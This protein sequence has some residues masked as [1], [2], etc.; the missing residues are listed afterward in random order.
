MTLPALLFSK[1]IPSFTS[2]NVSAI[3]PIILT[4]IFY[5]PYPFPSCE[6]GANALRSGPFLHLRR[7]HQ[8]GV[9]H[10]PQLSIRDSGSCY[11]VQLVSSS[12]E[13]WVEIWRRR[14]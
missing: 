7:N 9:P 6:G 3:G 13:S 11:L 14:S 4:G 8:G 12:C 10:A 1:I 2:E 5:S